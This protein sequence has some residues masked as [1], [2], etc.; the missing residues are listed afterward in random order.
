MRADLHIHTTASD[1]AWSPEQVVRGAVDGRLDVVAVADHDT[2]VGVRPAIRAS[3]GS[4]LTIVPA[5]ELSTSRD[6]RELHVLAYF[7][8]LDA[9][10]LRR[11]EERAR[12]SRLARMRTMVAR[13]TEAGVPVDMDAVL[14][15]AGGESGVVG[16]PHLAAALVRAGHVSSIAEAFDRYIGDGLPA[17]EP[18]A[19]MDPVAAVELA[20]ECGGVAVW[21]HPPGDLVD[22]VLPDLVRAGLRGLETYRPQSHPQQI[23]RLEGIART[24]GLFTT[25]GSDWHS[26]ERNE[27][28]GAF[29]VSGEGLARFLEEGGLSS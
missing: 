25:G 17:F 29:H 7:V 1:G 22:K 8:D 6:G 11:Y 24:A 23:R 18:T 13:L 15:S 14:A 10:V 20:R 21:A 5:L 26:P 9:S 2:T 3:E 12:S 28:L 16:R 4:T 19:M 27:P